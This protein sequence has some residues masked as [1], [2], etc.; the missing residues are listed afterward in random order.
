MMEIAAKHA[1]IWESSY[2]SSGHFASLK[3]KFEEIYSDK[4]N[5]ASKIM[6]SIELDVI[7]ANSD[8]D[9]EYKKRVFAMERGPAILHQLLR[10]SLVGKPKS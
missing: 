1:D 9:L 7:I 4:F 6:K 10:H 3:L 2:L 8:S 5:N